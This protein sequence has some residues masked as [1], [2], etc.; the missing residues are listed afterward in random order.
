M[1][2]QSWNVM[3][4]PDPTLDP[5]VQKFELMRSL[6]PGTITTPAL[7]RHFGIEDDSD[8]SSWFVASDRSLPEE[9]RIV[10]SVND[11]GVVDLSLVRNYRST[12][13]NTY[14]LD[15]LD[16]A[17]FVLMPIPYRRGGVFPRP[18]MMYIGGLKQEDPFL[19]K[20][21]EW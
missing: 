8:D 13:W 2:D 16:D 7:M 12:S 4:K 11:N 3:I 20:T 21:R 1:F 10:M 19:F 15:Y 14:G 17:T 9:R 6:L 5:F 18:Q